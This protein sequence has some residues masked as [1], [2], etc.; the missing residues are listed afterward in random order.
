[1]RVGKVV[2]VALALMVGGMAL[3]LWWTGRPPRRPASLSS[4]ALHFEPSNVPF[5]LRQT[6]YWLDCWLDE[7]ANVDRCKLTDV[8]GNVLFEDAF[9]PCRGRSPVP[10]SDLVFDTRRTGYTWLGSYEKGI[11]VP[12]IYLMNGQL[13]LLRSAYEEGKRT[14]GCPEGGRGRP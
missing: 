12:V 9:L 1:M 8:K 14:V 10:K 11:N 3:V 13:L 7:P 6:G 2:G 5:T 4:N